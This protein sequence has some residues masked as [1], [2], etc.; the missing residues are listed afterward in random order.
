MIQLTRFGAEKYA[1]RVV[2]RIPKG[3]RVWCVNRDEIRG[4]LPICQVVTGYKVNTETLMAVPMPERDAQIV[5]TAAMRYGAGTVEDAQKVLSRPSGKALRMV[6]QAEE[7]L[8]KYT[9]KRGGRK[10]TDGC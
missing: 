8:R 6:M 4:Y 5:S 10:K 2:K 9:T 1:L 3:Y 7:I